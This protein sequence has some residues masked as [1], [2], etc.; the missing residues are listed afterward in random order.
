MIAFT[1]IPGCCG[2]FA[3]RTLELK[4]RPLARD[5]GAY[6]LSL[7][8]LYKCFDDGTVSLHESAV[9]LSMYAA[10]ILVVVFSAGWG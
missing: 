1:V 5:L 8:W 9:M 10:Y 2:V 4:R 3:G 6:I 7:L